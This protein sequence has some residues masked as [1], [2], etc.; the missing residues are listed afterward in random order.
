M[1]RQEG[2]QQQSS[3]GVG[4]QLP[5]PRAAP[6]TMPSPPP[7]ELGLSRAILPAQGVREWVQTLHGESGMRSH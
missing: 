6:P 5:V 4:T 2:H 7:W 1:P 3:L